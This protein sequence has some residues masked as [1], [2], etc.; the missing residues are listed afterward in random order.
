MNITRTLARH[1][2]DEL[3]EKMVLIGGPR[4][5][6]KATLARGFV[7]NPAQYFSWD[8]LEHRAKLKSRKIDPGLGTVVLDEIH[9]Y[10]RWR[11]LLKGLYDSFVTGA[12]QLINSL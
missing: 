8:N 11:T 1:I 7:S 10:A 2:S 4:Q 9:K 5:V 3:S 12:G 6:G